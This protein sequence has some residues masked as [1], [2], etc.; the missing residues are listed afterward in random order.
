M[1]TAI[2]LICFPIA[3]IVTHSLNLLCVSSG[4][5]IHDNLFSL[6]V[7]ESIINNVMLV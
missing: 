4:V 7:M 2:Y 1:P 6:N 3:K 5:A